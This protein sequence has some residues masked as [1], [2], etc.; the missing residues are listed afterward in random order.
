MLKYI[1]RSIFLRLLSANLLK[2]EQIKA[3]AEI[4]GTVQKYHLQYNGKA[5]FEYLQDQ[6]KSPTELR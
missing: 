6:S 2:S 3:T 5:I 4:T 1:S